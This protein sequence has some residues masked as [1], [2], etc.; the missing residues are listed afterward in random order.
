MSIDDRQPNYA[1]DLYLRLPYFFGPAA[2]RPSEPSCVLEIKYNGRR[3]QAAS[4]EPASR[5][6]HRLE[7]QSGHSTEAAQGTS[8]PAHKIL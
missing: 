6:R 3:I 7:L 4:R 2:C 8:H 1:A 5:T